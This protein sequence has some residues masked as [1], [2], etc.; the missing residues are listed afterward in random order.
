MLFWNEIIY[1]ALLFLTSDLIVFVLSSKALALVEIAPFQPDK[2]DALLCKEREGEELGTLFLLF[3]LRLCP[4]SFSFHPWSCK[5]IH[6]S[7]VLGPNKKQRFLL[8]K[9]SCCLSSSNTLQ[10]ESGEI[11]FCL[12][13]FFSPIEDKSATGKKQAKTQPR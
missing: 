9:E 10:K 8:K 4:Q 6:F 3:F 11:W 5:S 12:L 1:V 13:L 7:T 2:K